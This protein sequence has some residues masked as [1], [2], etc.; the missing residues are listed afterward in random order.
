MKTR[1]GK[2][3]V[4]AAFI[5]ITP[6]V[7]VA[8]NLSSQ[9]GLVNRNVERL[10]LLTGPNLLSPARTTPTMMPS[11]MILGSGSSLSFPLFEPTSLMRSGIKESESARAP[12]FLKG[13]IRPAAEFLRFDSTLRTPPAPPK[14]EFQ[15]VP[16][17]D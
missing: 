2:A 11:S 17:R 3:T 9:V 4:A 8:Q 10:T 16:K 14:F 1:V 12:S 6:L 15:A 5:C 7:L 13:I